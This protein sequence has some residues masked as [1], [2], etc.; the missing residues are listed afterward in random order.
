AAFHT[1]GPA[2]SIFAGCETV[3]RLTVREGS[4]VQ[5][6]KGAWTTAQPW[7]RAAGACA[8]VPLLLAGCDPAPTEAL[9]RSGQVDALFAEFTAGV[10]P[11]AAVMVIENGEIVHR[12]GYGYANLEER[13]PIDAD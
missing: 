1:M 4:G 2:A 13:R 9:T 8:L 6:V 5:A 11:G 7:I 10:Q 12:A 3:V